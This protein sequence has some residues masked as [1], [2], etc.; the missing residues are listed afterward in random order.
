MDELLV[1][2]FFIQY[3]LRMVEL[4][5]RLLGGDYSGWDDRVSRHQW[6][7]QE[8][9]SERVK[10]VACWEEIRLLIKNR[11]FVAV[12]GG[13]K[14]VIYCSNYDGSSS[15][16]FSR[17]GCEGSRFD[18]R[19]GIIQVSAI[20]GEKGLN[21]RRRSHPLGF[22]AAILR[23]ATFWD[24]G[25]SS[26]GSKSLNGPGAYDPP[27]ALRKKTS[28]KNITEEEK[29]P[30]ALLRLDAGIKKLG[31][32]NAYFPC[33]VSQDRAKASGLLYVY[34]YMLYVNI[35][36]YIHLCS[37]VFHVFRAILFVHWFD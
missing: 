7:P 12:S 32:D 22:V 33:F 19:Y 5:T 18:R 4:L 9:Q 2:G 15:R 10:M 28:L 6:V 35:N 17:M 37:V 25:P 3:N 16:I 36:I 8:K 1:P 11:R 27:R 29:P 23:G 34:I 20:K 31:V 14:T 26:F 13:T 30:V 24:P 21:I